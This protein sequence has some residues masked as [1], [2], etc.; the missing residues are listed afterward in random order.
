MEFPM[1]THRFRL[2]MGG[3][4]V[5]EFD[6]MMGLDSTLGGVPAGPQRPKQGRITMRKGVA[7]GEEQAAWY[8]GMS[9]KDIEPKDVDIVLLNDG[10]PVARWKMR[11]AWP[12]KY[13]SLDLKAGNE[14]A[15]ELLELVCGSQAREM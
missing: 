7:I 10:A 3:A 8:K 4:A 5:A 6:E 13:E 9:G 1:Q 2:E 14:E 11:K 12:V 15:I